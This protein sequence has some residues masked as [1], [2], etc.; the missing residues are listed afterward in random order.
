M[1]I[2]R[3]KAKLPF[4]SPARTQTGLAPHDRHWVEARDR[5]VQR[6]A[7][8]A[9]M[10]DCASEPLAAAHDA[11]TTVRSGGARDK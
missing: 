5:H 9:V 8:R 1:A 7:R 10:P 2:K 11:V 6:I 3:N 4:V